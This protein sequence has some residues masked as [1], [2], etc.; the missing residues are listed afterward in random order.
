MPRPKESDYTAPRPDCPHPEH[1]TSPGPDS[2]EVEVS[3]LVAAFVR[4]LKP[5]LAIETGTGF[6]QTAEHIG[7]ALV[8]NGLGRLVSLET[9]PSRVEIARERCAGLPV[10]VLEMSSLEYVPNGEIGF[11]W[12]DS[13]EELRSPEISR[14]AQWVSPRCVVGIHDTGPHKGLRHELTKLVGEGLLTNPL[15]LP[16]PRGVCFCRFRD[17]LW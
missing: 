3:R 16:T 1:W 10:D 13:L 6:G 17:G 15:Y 9:D 7:R 5:E 8:R 11:L 4:A 12:I 2:A 14:F